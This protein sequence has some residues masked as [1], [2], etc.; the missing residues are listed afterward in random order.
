MMKKKA[1]IKE[2][3]GGRYGKMGEYVALIDVELKPNGEPYKTK[4]EV[5][6]VLEV[7][8]KGY[9]YGNAC[10]SRSIVHFID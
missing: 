8:T 6:E 4:F 7:K 10:S 1:L 5:L 2:W 9:R 3:N